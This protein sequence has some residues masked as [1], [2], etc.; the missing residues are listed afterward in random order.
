MNRYLHQLKS[1][2]TWV[3]TQ[4]ELFRISKLPFCHVNLIKFQSPPFL[5][6]HVTF[7]VFVSPSHNVKDSFV[8][9]LKVHI[10][11]G[12]RRAPSPLWHSGVACRGQQPECDAPGANQTSAAS[13]C[14]HSPRS[15]RHRT[16]PL[17]H[18]FEITGK[19]I[20]SINDVV[21]FDLAPSCV[22]Q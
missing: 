4:L 17:L 12:D 10:S 1:T 3:S 19:W 16:Q 8:L 5:Y 18:Y 14:F 21:I 20:F 2:N 9:K 11:D 22:L 6:S 15:L 13:Q 7:R